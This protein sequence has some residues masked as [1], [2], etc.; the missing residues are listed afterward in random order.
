M[1]SIMYSVYETVDG[2]NRR[3]VFNAPDNWLVN[4]ILLWP[5]QK[6]GLNL[7]RKT[8]KTPE[9]DWIQIHNYKILASNL[10][11]LLIASTKH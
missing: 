5:P 7:L 10:R 2:E 4:G 8:K 3:D 11:K 6:T 9:A 1:S